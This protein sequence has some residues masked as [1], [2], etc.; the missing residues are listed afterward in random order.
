M[1]VHHAWEL[2]HTAG[3]DPLEVA[4][5]VEAVKA[6]SDARQLGAIHQVSQEN[7]GTMDPTGH[8]CDP[9]PAEIAC[10]LT[11]TPAAASRRVD[12][13]HELHEDLPGVLDALRSGRLDLGKA[14]EIAAGTFGLTRAT[15]VALARIA[16]D[17]AVCHTRGQLRAW[18]AKQIARLD[19]EAATERRKKARTRRRVWVQPEADGMAT[20]GA[21]LT[22]EEARACYESLRLAVA[23]HEGPVDAAR[24]D[25][26][27]ARISGVQAHQPIPVQVLIT[28]TGPELVGYGPISGTHAEQLCDTAP[29]IYLDRPRPTIGYRPSPQLTRYVKARDRHC[30]FPGCRRPGSPLRRRPHHRL[31]HRIDRGIQSAVPVQMPPPDQDPHGLEGPSRPHRRPHLD[32]SSRPHLCQHPRRPMSQSPAGGASHPLHATEMA[33]AAP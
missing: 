16:C 20:L 30:R 31:A 3:A 4:R 19:P 15:R 10:A 25:E 5:A 7:P 18:L 8:L 2:L 11:W 12:L 23:N 27:V 26:L 14:Q 6:F 24:A 28:P 32:Q 1:D 17:Y 21:Y 22:A 9:A 33:P 29:R 13:A